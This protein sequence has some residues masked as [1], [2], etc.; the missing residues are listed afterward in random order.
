MMPFGGRKWQLA[1]QLANKTDLKF[2]Q[3]W[4]EK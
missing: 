3:K 4:R 2:E 1:Q